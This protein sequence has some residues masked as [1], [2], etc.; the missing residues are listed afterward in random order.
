MASIDSASS[1]AAGDAQRR[2]PSQVAP[3]PSAGAPQPARR[4]A[5]RR[6]RRPSARRARPPPTPRTR[7]CRRGSSPCRRSGRPP[8]HVRG[9][10]GR[11]GRRP[12]PPPPPRRRGAARRAGPRMSVST[13]WSDAVTT[14]VGVLLVVTPV[15]LRRATG[16]RVLVRRIPRPGQPAQVL[17]GLDGD[18]L[19]DPAQVAGIV[20]RRPARTCSCARSRGPSDH[21]AGPRTRIPARARNAP[22]AEASARPARAVTMARTRRGT[23]ADTTSRTAIRRGPTTSPPCSRSYSS[24]PGAPSKSAP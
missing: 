4:P 9:P 18:G 17:G 20:C 11:A 6:R 15:G 14:S 23:A 7:A 16:R 3:A 2:C 5:R 22:Y 24:R 10:P 1:E 21:N 8:R 12:A 13:A 19:G